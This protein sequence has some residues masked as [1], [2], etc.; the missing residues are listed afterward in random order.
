ME[1]TRGDIFYIGIP[2]GTGHEMLKSRPGVVISGDALNKSSTCVTVVMC[3]ASNKRDLPEHIVLRSTPLIST[4][5]CE[6]I[7]TVDK[8]RLEQRMGRCSKSELAAIDIGI[9]AALGLDA[10]G[11]A[12]PVEADE[13]EAPVCGPFPLVEPNMEL[14]IARI[15]RDTYKRL[16]ESLMDRMSMERRTGA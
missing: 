1:I 10:Y 3:S 8:S 14:A 4:A 15:E 16:Y 6:H 9:M 12:R 13:E 11:L 5:M 7:Y 2:G